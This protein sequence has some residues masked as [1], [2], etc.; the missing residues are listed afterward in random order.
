LSP[1]VLLQETRWVQSQ[2]FKYVNV[3]DC[4]GAT[5]ERASNTS[6]NVRGTWDSETYPF[7]YSLNQ[8]IKQQFIHSSIHP[9]IQQSTHTLNSFF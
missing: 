6:I 4:W 9:S 8:S 7:I 5:L 1:G 2:P 3:W